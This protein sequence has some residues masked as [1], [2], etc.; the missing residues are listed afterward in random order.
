MKKQTETPQEALLTILNTFISDLESE[1]RDGAQDYD[2]MGDSKTT[3]RDKALYLKGSRDYIKKIK[4]FK[5]KFESG[6]YLV[7]DISK[8]INVTI[9]D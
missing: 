7:L 6:K 4:S 9:E 3:K 8:P 2:L 5:K 1:M